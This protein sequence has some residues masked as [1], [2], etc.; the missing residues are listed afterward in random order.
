MTHE[1]QEQLK[2]IDPDDDEQIDAFM[3]QMRANAQAR[4]LKKNNTH[5]FKLSELTSISGGGGRQPHMGR[6]SDKK[7]KNKKKRKSG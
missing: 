6:P 5:N 4:A 3:E 7:P 2:Q 1:E